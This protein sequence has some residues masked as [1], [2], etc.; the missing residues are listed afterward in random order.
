MGVHL[1]VAGACG[2]SREVVVGLRVLS[3]VFVKES[4]DLFDELQTKIKGEVTRDDKTLVEY[5]TDA[6]LF[7]VRPQVVVFPQNSEDVQE[8]IRFVNEHRGQDAHLS[9]TARAAGTDMSGGPLNESIIMG[10]TKHM[11]EILGFDGDSVRVQPG[12]YYRD[13]EKETLKRNLLLPSYPASKLL[14][15]LG[16]MVNNNSGGEKTLRYGKTNKYVAGL[17]M[18]LA[19]GNE[20]MFKKITKTELNKKR[21]LE[22]FEGDVYRKV[23]DLIQKNYNVIQ[24]ARPHVSKNSAGYA[25]WD[26]WDKKSQMF[27]LTQL[28]VGAQGTL[29]IMTEATLKLIEPK[30][31]T[32]LAVL[33]MKS[34]DE[35]PSIVNAL[36]PLDPEGLETF[37]DETLKLGL[38]F[39]PEIAS[40]V[41]GQ[42]TLGLALQF[43]PEFFI[44]LRMLGLP[45]LVVLVEFA[46]N[47]DTEAERKLSELERVLKPFNVHKRIFHTKEKA[48]KYWVMRRES[49]LLLR[50]HVSGK[51]AAPFIDDLIVDPQKLPEFLPKVLKI[52]KDY[53]I[54]T[55]LAGHAGSGNFHIIPL[56]DLS[57]PEEVAKIPEISDKVYD[58]IIEYGGSITAEH[59]DG[60]IRSPYLEKMFGTQVYELFEEVKQIFDPDNIFN[61]GKKVHADLDYAMKHIHH[62]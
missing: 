49:F 19:D 26:V 27:D 62:V 61:P 42:S 9:L 53:N 46:E 44:G 20:Y 29:G 6:S 33:F 38:R 10:F 43:L 14:A 3:A 13:F 25:L 59:N 31:Y 22:N 28:F 39:L 24:Q 16:G 45:K 5:S 55:T 32:K 11:N 50:K 17:N 30:P 52:L 57:K 54:H 58:L 48:E 4:M 40:R 15:A 60:L 21:A 51:R 37:D 7:E 47:S 36:L 12:M 34:W 18:V 41:E 23:D 56:M 1:Y 8:L 35:L 2:D